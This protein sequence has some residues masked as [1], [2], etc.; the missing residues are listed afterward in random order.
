M[1]ESLTIMSRE[2]I[3]EHTEHTEHTE[4]LP[5]IFYMCFVVDKKLI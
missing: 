4:K 1:Y 2:K 5:V 3:S